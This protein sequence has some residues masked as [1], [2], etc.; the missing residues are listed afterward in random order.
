MTTAA[1][2]VP[3]SVFAMRLSVSSGVISLGNRLNRSRSTL[4]FMVSMSMLRMVLFLFCRPSY[5]LH[6]WSLFSLIFS[7]S[8]AAAAA[9]M[10]PI[11]C[12]LPLLCWN[13]TL[14]FLCRLRDRIGRFRH[15]FFL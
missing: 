9:V 2:T 8:T 4:L 7:L 12:S 14:F 11:I 3:R 6:D 10:E 1:G 15:R 13:R 5:L